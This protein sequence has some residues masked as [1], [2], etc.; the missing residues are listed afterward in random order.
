MRRNRVERTF[1]SFAGPRC[2]TTLPTA[3]IF[4]DRKEQPRDSPLARGEREEVS[5]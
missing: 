1:L 4:V 3:C 5:A 2:R